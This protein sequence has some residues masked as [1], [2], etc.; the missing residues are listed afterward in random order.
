VATAARPKVCYQ[1]ADI[2]EVPPSAAGSSDGNVAI[3]STTV[4]TVTECEGS[5]RF[6]NVYT[7]IT[8]AISVEVI[9]AKILNVHFLIHF[10][11]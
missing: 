6:N 5:P 7:S 1:L 4:R 3:D 9:V 8:N 10:E 2:R 11:G